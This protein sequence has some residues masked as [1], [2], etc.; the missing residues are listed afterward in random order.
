MSYVL[1]TIKELIQEWGKLDVEN[2]MNDLKYDEKYVPIHWNRIPLYIYCFSQ[3]GAYTSIEH[4]LLH[5][6][7]LCELDPRANWKYP[8]L[9]LE[10]KAVPIK[11]PSK[12]NKE[13][14]YWA[15]GTGYGWTQVTLG[16]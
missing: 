11:S 3:S 10:K 9:K 2:P 13:N 4:L 14:Q 1:T 12:E 6:E 15:S 8:E 7:K 5:L 16:I